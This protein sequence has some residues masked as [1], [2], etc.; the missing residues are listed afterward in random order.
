MNKSGSVSDQSGWAYENQQYIWDLY[1]SISQ[2]IDAVIFIVGKQDK[3]I[4]YV[5]ENADRVLGIPSS[6]A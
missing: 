2:N 4:E 5:F 1:Q 3:K 6:S